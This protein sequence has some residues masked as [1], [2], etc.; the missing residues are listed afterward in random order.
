[1]LLPA[2]SPLG[3]EWHVALAAAGPWKDGSH[4]AT[5]C[6]LEGSEGKCGAQPFQLS[7]CS[8]Q[9]AL[10]QR[11]VCSKMSLGL[12]HKGMHGLWRMF[13]SN[14]SILCSDQSGEVQANVVTCWN[15]VAPPAWIQAMQC[16]E[17]KTCHSWCA[18]LVIISKISQ[19]A[20]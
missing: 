17:S 9:F 20:T 1:M 7:F 15:A 19:T 4:T 14:C 8:L 16:I 11:L 6:S 5:S 2:P 13:W 10:W 18:S 12:L 3:T